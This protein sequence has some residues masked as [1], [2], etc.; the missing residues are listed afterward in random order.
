MEQDGY[1]TKGQVLTFL[2]PVLSALLCSVMQLIYCYSKTSEPFFIDYIEVKL[3]FMIIWFTILFI[4]M[5][6]FVVQ[7]SGSQFFCKC[8]RIFRFPLWYHPKANRCLTRYYA[9]WL[10]VHASFI[11]C[12]TATTITLPALCSMNPGAVVLLTVTLHQVRIQISMLP[13]MLLIFLFV[14]SMHLSLR[15]ILLFMTP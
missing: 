10:F 6:A 1:G 12:V 15:L 9:C 2:R 8:S 3:I 5:M 7:S 14:L 11:F 4:L 13:I